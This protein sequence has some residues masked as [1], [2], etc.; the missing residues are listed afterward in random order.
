MWNQLAD[1]SALASLANDYTLLANEFEKFFD[2]FTIADV[3]L[4]PLL[5][6]PIFHELRV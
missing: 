5:E 4:L 3:L 1:P 6:Q 2:F